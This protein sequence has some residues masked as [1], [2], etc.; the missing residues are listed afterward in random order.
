MLIQLGLFGQAGQFTARLL[1]LLVHNTLQE[2]ADQVGELIEMLVHQALVSAGRDI[3]L[4]V[5]AAH[6]VSDVAE[7]LV[8]LLLGAFELDSRGPRP[9]LVPLHQCPDGRANGQGGKYGGREEGG[10]QR[11]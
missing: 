11:G 2:I 3:D 5:V 10:D 6:L 1:G 9:A 8:Q 7:V 4:E